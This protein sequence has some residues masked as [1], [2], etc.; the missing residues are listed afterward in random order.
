L[1]GRAVAGTDAPGSEVAPL[2]TGAAGERSRR[3]LIDGGAGLAININIQL[4]LP[5]TTDESVYD[6]LFSSLRKHVL[7]WMERPSD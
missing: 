7:E 5:D 4:A 1:V 2:G 6:N 3:G